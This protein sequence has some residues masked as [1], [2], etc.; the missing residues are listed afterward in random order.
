[1]LTVKH[2]AWALGRDGNLHVKTNRLIDRLI[3]GSA[4]AD[5]IRALKKPVSETA[6]NQNGSD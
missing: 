3:I 4:D 6:E 5:K 1:V 2:A